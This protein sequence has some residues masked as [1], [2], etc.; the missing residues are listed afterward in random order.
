MDS[1][2]SVFNFKMQ[3]SHLSDCRLKQYLI[4]LVF[5]TDPSPVPDK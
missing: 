4:C 5:I 1:E 2:F 3:D